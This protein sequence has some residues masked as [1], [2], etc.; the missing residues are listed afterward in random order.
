[1]CIILLIIYKY[2]YETCLLWITSEMLKLREH[3]TH[4][5]VGL[6]MDQELVTSA[7][8]FIMH[9]TSMLLS[10]TSSPPIT[11]MLLSAIN[12]LP[13]SG[14][15]VPVTSAPYSSLIWLVGPSLVRVPALATEHAYTFGYVWN[16]SLP[17]EFH[18][19]FDDDKR[20]GLSNNLK[21]LLHLSY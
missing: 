6:D 20:E 5:A 1:M 12:R 7:C 11:D 4:M 21:Y 15:Q 16:A 9:I 13:I 14:N 2:K 18:A 3:V 8:S 19:P 10:L 17:I